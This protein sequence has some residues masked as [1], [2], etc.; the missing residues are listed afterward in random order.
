MADL[1]LRV[2]AVGRLPQAPAILDPFNE[3]PAIQE[4]V[5]ARWTEVLD[6]MVEERLITQEQHDQALR[7][8]YSLVPPEAPLRAPHFT[9]YAQQQ[10]ESLMTE[11]GYSPEDV[12]RG[13]TGCMLSISNQRHGGAHRQ[14]SSRGTIVIQRLERSRRCDPTRNRRNIRHGGQCR[15]QQ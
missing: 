12:A 4:A 11:L 7:Q 6:R 15:L 10:L 9:V 3:D 5:I 1:T 13:A 2:S 8:G 14:Q